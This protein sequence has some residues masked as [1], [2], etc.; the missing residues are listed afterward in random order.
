MK[1]ARD[2]YHANREK[3]RDYQ[4]ERYK[5]DPK[6]YNLLSKNSRKKHFPRTRDEVFSHYSSRCKCCG[7]DDVRFLTID[8]IYGGKSKFYKKYPS[9]KPAYKGYELA[10][11]LKRNNYPAGF[12]LLCMNCNAAKGFRG[13]NGLCPHNGPTVKIK[14]LKSLL[15]T[16]NKV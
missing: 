8:H 2:F 13:N 12:Q 4:L 9:Y 3:I 10:A 1:R 5:K 7:L 6:K 15:F 11:W 14:H 16:D